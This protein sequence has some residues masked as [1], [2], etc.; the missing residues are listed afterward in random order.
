L[1][2][3]GKNH[4]DRSQGIRSRLAMETNIPNNSSSAPAQTSALPGI[5]PELA[6][7]KI[8]VIDDEP[9][10]VALLKDI[11]ADNGYARVK[12]ITDSRLVL[13]SRKTFQPDLI[14]LDLVMPHVDGFAVLEALRA[15]AGEVLVP[16]IVLTADANEEAKLR[17]LRAG[18]TDFLL[19]PFDQLE[20]LLRIGN[21]LEMRRLHVQLDNQRAAFEEAVH[22]RTTELRQTQLELEKSNWRNS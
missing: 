9:V 12:S 15:E 1:A 16:V 17:A 6:K 4:P 13:E 22:A 10:N 19:K 2:R 5:S 14:L 18:A 21:L 8:L 11:L 7:M 20:V 3:P